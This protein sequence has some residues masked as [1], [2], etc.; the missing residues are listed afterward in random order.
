[1]CRLW[2]VDVSVCRKVVS[3]LGSVLLVLL[4]VSCIWL[5]MF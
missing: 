2:W 4:G 5:F 1:M 3:V